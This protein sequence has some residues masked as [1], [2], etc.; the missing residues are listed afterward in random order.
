MRRFLFLTLLAAGLAVAADN[1]PLRAQPGP[2][3]WPPR[4]DWAPVPNLNGLW[5]LTGDPAKPCRIYQRPGS[6]RALFVNEHG[7]RATG[8]IRGNQI[9]IPDWGPDN[10]GQAGTYRGDRIIWEP[11]GNYWQR[12]DSDFPPERW[13]RR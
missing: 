8:W 4:G 12:A 2:D 13:R 5:V 11:D 6:S 3:R 7:S 10:E 9:W 1:A